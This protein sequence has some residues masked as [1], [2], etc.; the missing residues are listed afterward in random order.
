MRLPR[1]QR[2]KLYVD[3]DRAD[4]SFF[5]TLSLTTKKAKIYPIEETRMPS[6]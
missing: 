3:R 6:S 4:M 1:G 2:T 5:G